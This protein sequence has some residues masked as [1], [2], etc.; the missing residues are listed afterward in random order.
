MAAAPGTIPALPQYQP[1]ALPLAGTEALEIVNTT[2]A[3]TAAS[4]YI[5]LTDL[6]GKAPSVMSNSNPESS[7][8]FTFYRPGSG[9]YFSGLVGNLAVIAGNLPVAGNTGQFLRKASGTN[10]DASWV[11]LSSNVA[12]GTSISVAGST[13]LVVS[14]PNFG[15]GTAQIATFAI[16]TDKIATSAVVTDKIADFAVTSSKI[17][18]GAVGPDQLATGVITSTYIANHAVGPLQLA[19]F[20][21]V[22]TSIATG[23]V[24]STQL[25]A[26]SVQSAKIATFAVLSSHIATFAVNTPQIATSAVSL[27]RIQNISGL[28]VI[29]NA[30]ST[31]GTAVVI[32]AIGGSRVLVTDDAGPILAFAPQ[33]TIVS[34][35]LAS[36][37]N[38]VLGSTQGM[39]TYRNS[40]SWVALAAGTAGFVLQT[41]GSSANP[42]WVGS[43]VL[44][45]T[46]TPTNVASTTDTTSLTSR[47]SRYEISFENVAAISTAT[48]TTGLQ[49]R[50]STS[51]TSW[52]STQYVSTMYTNNGTTGNRASTTTFVLVSDDTAGFATSTTGVSGVLDIFNP[53]S[54]RRK[55]MNGRVTSIAG[56][57]LSSSNVNHS[58]FA[59]VWASTAPVVGLA[60]QMTTGTIASGTIRIYGIV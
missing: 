10:F 27:N 51:G 28:S 5:L 34:Q 26:V 24:G 42:Q 16:I 60:F 3:T 57:A 36:A 45:N 40:A 8:L 29:G 38:G 43:K 59:S 48:N 12:A 30:G 53:S 23:A 17:A 52:E 11:N 39:I 31:L 13:S 33:T 32:A 47:Y 25:G 15:I 35:N 7:D 9:L 20:A 56:G 14:I 18:T 21:V 6:V 50:V 2:N 54:D 49:M 37:M 58:E 44:L 22:A 46:L 1:A 55:M 41:L 4:F 19:T